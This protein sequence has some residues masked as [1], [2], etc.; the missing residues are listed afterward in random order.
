MRSFIWENIADKSSPVYIPKTRLG[1]SSYL[2]T[3]TIH[4]DMH[5]LRSWPPAISW[6]YRPINS[7]FSLLGVTATKKNS[8]LSSMLSSIYP[9]RISSYWLP[10]STTVVLPTVKHPYKIYCDTELKK[11][12]SGSTRIELYNYTRKYRIPSF[13]TTSRPQISFW[14]NVKRFSTRAMFLWL[15]SFIESS[16][17]PNSGISANFSIWREILLSTS[18]TVIRLSKLSLMPDN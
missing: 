7:S 8:A 1:I 4:V 18:P 17:D 10:V 15:F 5:S 14:F 6:D 11:R 16:Q 2:I 3:Y 13:L 9:C 12:N